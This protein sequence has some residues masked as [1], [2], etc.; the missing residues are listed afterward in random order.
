MLQVSADDLKAIVPYDDVRFHEGLKRVLAHPALEYIFREFFPEGNPT[1]LRAKAS[2]LKSTRE[3]QLGFIDPFLKTIEEKS[4]SGITLSGDEH[5]VKDRSYLFISNHRDII[6]DPA[7]FTVMLSRKG[8]KSPQICLGDNLLTDPLIVDLVKMNKGLTVKRNLS[9]R[10]LLRWS[11][12]LSAQ[13]RQTL[14][15][16]NESVWIAQQ[17]GRA[18]DGNDQTHPGVLKMIALA[19][20]GSFLERLSKISM[21][22][23]AISYEY[24]PS[25]AQKARET[26]LRQKAGSYN[27]ARGE[28]TQAMI[29]GMREFKG[30]IQIN[31]GPSVNDCLPALQKLA[32]KS[33][34]VRNLATELDS[35]IQS[36]YRNYPSNYVAYDLLHGGTQMR[37]RYSDGKRREFLELME[38]RVGSLHLDE[39]DLDGVKH[40]FLAMYARSVENQIPREGNAERNVDQSLC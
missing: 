1:A 26:F 4:T 36:Q 24:D 37:E 10:E 18:K 3:F 31:I 27:K 40:E 9:P 22:P 39:K 17:E 34:Q 35:R 21:V 8:F 5:L 15:S 25:D 28:D 30:A 14:T 11:Y 23:V 6:L 32:N 12:V 2:T 20:E 16:A 7:L 19:G 13:I 29:R 38:T 33:E